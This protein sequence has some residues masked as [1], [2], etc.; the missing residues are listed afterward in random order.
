MAFKQ[1]GSPMQ[2][3]FGIGSPMKQKTIELRE[4]DEY[5]NKEGKSQ[6]DIYN[7]RTKNL[8]TQEGRM[9]KMEG[10]IKANQNNKNLTQ[11][12][13][14]EINEKAKSI[15]IDYDKAFNAYT[16]SMDSIQNVNKNID[17]LKIKK[18]DEIDL[19]F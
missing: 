14:N 1:K 17:A 7:K 10:I 9:N 2:R 13:A 6:E 12:K 11:K 8:K 16:T 5:L 3:N 4:G 18:S 19:D 15:Q